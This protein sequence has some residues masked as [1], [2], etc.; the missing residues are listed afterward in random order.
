MGAPRLQPPPGN[1]QTA[2]TGVFTHKRLCEHWEA[3]FSAQP[4]PHFLMVNCLEIA[5]GLWLIS[6]LSVG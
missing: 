5:Q 2:A 4:Q 3:T 1:T 6:W